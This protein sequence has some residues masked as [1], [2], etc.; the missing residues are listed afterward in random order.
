MY[1]CVCVR[2]YIYI[3]IT[4]S[5]YTFVLCWPQTDDQQREQKLINLFARAKMRIIQCYVKHGSQWKEHHLGCPTEKPVVEKKKSYE[6]LSLGWVFLTQIKTKKSKP[7]T[8]AYLCTTI[9][10]FLDDREIHPYQDVLYNIN[11]LLLDTF[12]CTSVT[13]CKAFT[14]RLISAS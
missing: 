1:V 7:S 9:Y 8:G 4:A 12:F 11:L 14:C 6:M 13:Y 2:V 5:L 10:A 3:Y